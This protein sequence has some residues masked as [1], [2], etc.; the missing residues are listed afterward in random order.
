MDYKKYFVKKGDSIVF[1]GDKLEIFVPDRYG[2]SHGFLEITNSVKTL[3]IFDM[4]VNDS[5]DIGYLLGAKIEIVPSEISTVSIDGQKF[6]KLLLNKNDIFIKGEK[7]ISSEQVLYMVFYEMVF[8]GHYPNFIKYN[9][10]ATLFDNVLRATGGSFNTDHM[11]FEMIGAVLNRNAADITEEYRLTDMKKEPKVL[12][13][14]AIGYVSKSTTGK[15]L[16]NY[17]NEGVDSVLVNTADTT[18]E[19]ENLLR[20]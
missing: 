5:I 16:G 2:G 19:I 11:I 18:S 4:V 9:D 8:S 7:I 17:M 10:V 20:Q 3:G 14:R 13:L 15:I 1:I 12:P 6:H